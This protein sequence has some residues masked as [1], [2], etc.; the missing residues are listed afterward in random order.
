[1]KKFDFIIGYDIMDLQMNKKFHP[2]HTWVD[3]SWM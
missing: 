3:G 1:M 2:A